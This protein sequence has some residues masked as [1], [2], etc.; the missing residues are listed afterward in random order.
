MLVV[1]EKQRMVKGIIE[2]TLVDMDTNASARYTERGLIKAIENGEEVLDTKIV[3]G[4]IIVE[5]EYSPVYTMSGIIDVYNEG[6]ICKIKGIRVVYKCWDNNYNRVVYVNDPISVPKD[7]M[8]IENNREKEI[9]IHNK[10]EGLI[11]KNKILGLKYDIGCSVEGENVILHDLYCESDTIVIPKFIDSIT[12]K[13]LRKFYISPTKRRLIIKNSK[14]KIAD[15]TFRGMAKNNGIDGDD[16]KEI[17]D[18]IGYVHSNIKK[19]IRGD[20]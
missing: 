11:N 2:Y 5:K 18:S 8:T 9:D 10:C 7:I 14:V 6:F 13:S 15:G 3:D 19:N 20:E 1:V 16:I 17:L 4:K 12:D